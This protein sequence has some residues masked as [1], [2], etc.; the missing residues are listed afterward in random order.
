MSKSTFAVYLPD[1]YAPVCIEA[2]SFV[3]YGGELVLHKDEQM[4]GRSSD[5]GFLVRSDLV[6]EHTL[7]DGLMPGQPAELFAPA[8][9]A[10]LKLSSAVWPFAAGLALGLLL[11]IGTAVALLAR[12]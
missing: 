12:L 4:V 2:D 7:S 8:E 6:R 3:Y 5:R 10:N 9:A 1:R 11:G